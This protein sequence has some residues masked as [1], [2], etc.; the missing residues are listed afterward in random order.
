MKMDM[1][2]FM[3][4]LTI[5]TLF[6]PVLRDFYMTFSVFPSVQKICFKKTFVVCYVSRKNGN[7][8]FSKMKFLRHLS[9]H[10]AERNLTLN[11]R[12]YWSG[13]KRFVLKPRWNHDVIANLAGASS[14]I[15]ALATKK[16]IKKKQHI[17]DSNNS[18]TNN[19]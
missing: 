6:L 9:W 14:I 19:L 12:W 10:I 2:S 17:H 13:C 8:L 4:N 1:Y 3:Y 7:I 5:S 16:C 11:K 18:K 15:V